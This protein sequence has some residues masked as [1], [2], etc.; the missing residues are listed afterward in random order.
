MIMIEKIA[1]IIEGQV[2]DGFTSED[3][4]RG[5]HEATVRIAREFADYFTKNVPFFDWRK[6]MKACDLEDK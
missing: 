3:Y 6:F 4:D 2:D 1:Q 5:W